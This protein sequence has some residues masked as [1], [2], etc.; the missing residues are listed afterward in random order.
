MSCA[1]C[2]GPVRGYGWINPALARNDP[3]RANAF[4]RFCSM[5]CQN[6]YAQV[7]RQTGGVLPDMTDMERWALMQS[8]PAIG[9][10]I[11]SHQLTRPLHASSTH[12]VLG[13]FACVIAQYRLHMQQAFAAQAKRDADYFKRKR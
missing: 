12:D 4:R 3:A 13:L 1:V 11:Q 6:A 8:L 7:M 2:S 10:Y 5:S 9:Q